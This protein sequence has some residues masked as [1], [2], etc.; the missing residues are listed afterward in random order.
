M[1]TFFIRA[2]LT[3]AMLL[4]QVA[5]SQVSLHIT[6]APPPLPVYVQPQVPGDGYIWTPGYWV[7]SPDEGDYYWVPGTWVLAPTTGDLW[8][9]GYWAFENAAY[10]WRV[11]YWGRSVGYYGGLNYGHGYTGS[12][13]QGGHWDRGHFRYNRAASKVDRKF[14]RRAYE[15]RVVNRAPA[16]RASFHDGPQRPGRQNPGAGRGGPTA[17]QIRHEH[18]ALMMPAQRASKSRGVPPVAA[19]RRPSEFAAPGVERARAEPGLRNR[20]SAPALRAP[21]QKQ[22]PK[23][24]DA[25]NRGEPRQ[26]GRVPPAGQQDSPAGK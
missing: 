11:G 16:S 12:G 5:Q 19:T 10:F 9:P 4:P 20:T 24:E 14:A 26:K 25:P 22:H 7:W 3:L 18:Q 1:T 2:V 6:I 8:T 23:R 13:Y 15:T 17:D 21:Q